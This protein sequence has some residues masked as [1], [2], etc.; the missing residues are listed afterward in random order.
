MS[1]RRLRSARKK[2]KFTFN[3]DIQM[4]DIRFDKEDKLEQLFKEIKYDLNESF[5]VTISIN[6]KC[7]SLCQ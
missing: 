3:R 1:F 4:T 6:L 7:S 2:I 5:E